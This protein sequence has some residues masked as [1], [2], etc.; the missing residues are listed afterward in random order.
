MG[1]E[2]VDGGEGGRDEWAEEGVGE[3]GVGGLGHGGGIVEG[4]SVTD[5]RWVI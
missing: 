5:Q 3:M 4:R 2:V 1:V